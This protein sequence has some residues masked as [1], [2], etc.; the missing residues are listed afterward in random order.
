M[1]TVV[2]I[3][4]MLAAAGMAPA[5]VE[6]K[7]VQPCHGQL[8]PARENSE[9]IRGDEV[10]VRFTIAGVKMD[11]DGRVRLELTVAYADA[12]G[13]V[14]DKNTLP[15]QSVLALGGGSLPGIARV[16]I[17]PDTPTGEY[18]LQVTVTDRLSKESASFEH[19]FTVKEAEFALVAIRFYQDREGRSAAPAGGTVGQTNFIQLRAIGF[20]RS[21]G[22]YDLELTLQIFDAKGN[23]VMP[24]P[25][26]AMIH[27]KDPKVVR[28]AAA[29]P[30]TAD[31][32]LNRPGDFV[33]RITLTDNLVKKTVKFEAPV[34]VTALDASR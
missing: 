1:R 27:S 21:K 7:D 3:L 11:D 10:L 20:D 28:A 4:L 13:K 15:I 22:E 29:L 26:R 5:K 23:A 34:K 12:K 2:S 33:L 19:K 8:G 17:N 32:T 6:L 25:V 30:L 16:A 9:Y 24:K 31:I 14:I 18:T